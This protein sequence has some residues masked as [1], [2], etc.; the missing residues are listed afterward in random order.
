[1]EPNVQSTP[2]G[3]VVTYPLYGDESYAQMNPNLERSGSAKLAY[4]LTP[5]IKLSY[6]SLFSSRI[7]RDYDYTWIAIPDGNLRRYKDGRT[8]LV[9]MNH[10]LNKSM[11]YEIGVSSSFTEYHHYTFEDPYDSRYANPNYNQVTNDYGMHVAGNNLNR[12]RRW[13][14]TYG[15]L[16]NFS[17]QVNKL[18][19]L[20]VGYEVKVN[21]LFYE[22][23]D[24]VPL[25]P[26]QVFDPSGLPAPLVF[27]PSIPSDTSQGSYKIC[28]SSV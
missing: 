3:G 22:N 20:K 24:L 14:E 28:K 11:F 25:N 1:M 7:Y 16:G 18:H 5:T 10:S 2:T 17:W 8:N 19:L 15:S 12:F 4:Q 27:T 6:T 9:K 26:D 23:I 13:T 21:K